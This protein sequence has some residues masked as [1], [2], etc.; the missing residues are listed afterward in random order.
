MK[1]VNWSGYADMAA[2]GKSMGLITGTFTIPHLNDSKCY[3]GSSGYA[4]ASQRAD[5][6]GV[7]DGTVEQVGVSEY[8]GASRGLY[9]W[10]EM[11]PLVPVAFTGVHPGDRV[12]VGVVGDTPYQ[13]YELLFY[14]ITTGGQFQVSESCPVSRCKDSSAEIIEEAP[15]GG[16]AGGYNLADYGTTPFS[17]V[18]AISQD[19]KDGSLNAM[20]GK[21][22]SLKIT[23]VSPASSA[24]DPSVPGSL[25][26]EGSGF[27]GFTAVWKHAS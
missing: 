27:T 19:G 9:A 15:G 3:P 7:S 2:K 22:S 16:P 17:L 14:D 26:K 20:R 23:M 8:C 6:D 13:S 18:M 21:W 25:S 4:F 5:L 1:S 11:Y 10:Y 12:I 24:R